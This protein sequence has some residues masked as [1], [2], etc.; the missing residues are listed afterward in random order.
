R[1]MQG[2]SQQFGKTALQKLIY[3]L[4]TIYGVDCGY[5]FEFFT[6]GPYCS[7]IFSDLET[8]ELWEG[9]KVASKPLTGGYHITPGEHCAEIIEKGKKF[10][11]NSHVVKSLESLVKDFGQ[12]SAKDLELRATIIYIERDHKIDKGV[13]SWQELERLTHEIKP[14]FSRLEIEHAIK[15]LEAKRFIQPANRGCLLT[16][17]QTK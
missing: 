1:R 11:T 9:V 6:Y 3:L 10:L 15:E 14:K 12:M 5:S 4:Q 13:I 16:S 17:N 2:K 8:V 7:A